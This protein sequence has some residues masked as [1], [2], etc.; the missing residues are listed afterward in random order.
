MSKSRAGA[1]LLGAGIA[2]TSLLVTGGAAGAQPQQG[3]VAK[4][5][6]P[7]DV[8]PR[9]KCGF[10]KIWFP[11][12]RAYYTHCHET[13]HIVIRMANYN[14]VQNRYEDRCVGPGTTD[15]GDAFVWDDAWWRGTY[16]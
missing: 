7:A 12:Y 14:D 15:I 4:S 11:L 10:D 5:S 6:V 3:P 8:T 13:T 1:A 2:I 9:V 16:C